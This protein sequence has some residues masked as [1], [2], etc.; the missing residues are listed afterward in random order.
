[1]NSQDT[2]LTLLVAYFLPKLNL[3]AKDPIDILAAPNYMHMHFWVHVKVHPS[4]RQTEQTQIR[5]PRARVSSD[6]P[7]VLLK[8]IVVEF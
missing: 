6:L 7:N 4:Y 1:M 3:V 5:R 2:L 8:L